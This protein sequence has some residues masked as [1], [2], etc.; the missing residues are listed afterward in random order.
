MSY[1]TLENTCAS[2]I[3]L[4]H[5]QK[6]NDPF[7]NKT[8]RIS[9][10]KDNLFN[11]NSYEYNNNNLYTNAKSYKRIDVAYINYVGKILDIKQELLLTEKKLLEETSKEIK[12][13]QNKQTL[14]C[15][16]K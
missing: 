13:I 8:G 1:Y 7:I 5:N 10:Y 9:L 14:S 15:K 2:S 6:Y 12:L 16:Q 4:T 3:S 11:R